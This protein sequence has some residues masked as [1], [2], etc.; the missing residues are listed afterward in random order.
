M[1]AFAGQRKFQAPVSDDFSRG[2]LSAKQ[3]PSENAEPKHTGLIN[4][5]T[6]WWRRQMQG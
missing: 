2:L 5:L 3:S 4:S 6:A 1:K